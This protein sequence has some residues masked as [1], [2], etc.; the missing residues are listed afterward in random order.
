MQDCDLVSRRDV[1]GWRWH[2]DWRDCMEATL[3]RLVWLL[4]PKFAHYTFTIAAL[5]IVKG[6]FRG[7]GNGMTL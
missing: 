2:M 4:Y 5:R 7:N 3:E 1:C 6:M